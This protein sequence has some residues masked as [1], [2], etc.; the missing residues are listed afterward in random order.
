MTIRRHLDRFSWLAPVALMLLVFGGVLAHGWVNWDD[1]L[2]VLENPRLVPLSWRGLGQ[3]WIRPYRGLY[4]PVSYTAFAAETLF[5]R[6]VS[7]TAAPAAAVF[8]GVSLLVHAGCVG[9]VFR[10]LGRLE[11]TP[12]AAAA[13][14]ALFAI[15]PLQVESVAW[16]SEQRGLLAAFFSL[17][18]IEFFLRADCSSQSPF[19]SRDE[20]A[21]SLCFTT[22]LLCKPSA[23][24]AP[25]L[26]AVLATVSP[27]PRRPRRSAVVLGLWCLLAVATGWGTTALQPVDSGVAG[28]WRLRPIVAGNALAFYAGK[29]VLPRSL[30]IDYGLTP[31]AIATAPHALR[32]AIAVAVALAAVAVVPKLRG[33]RLPLAIFVVPLLPVLGFV[34]FSFEGISVVADRYAYLAMLGPAVAVAKAL[35][36]GRSRWRGAVVAGAIAVLAAGAWFQTAVWRDSVALAGRALAVNGGTRG[37]LNN[38]GLAFLERGR[39][40]EA[41]TCFEDAIACDPGYPRSR[42]NL[43]L[44]WH[45]TGRL[46]EAEQAYREALRLDTTYGLAR[47]NLGIVLGQTGRRDEAEREFLNALAID[48]DHV[49]AARNLANLRAI[50]PA[51]DRE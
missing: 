40:A 18:A 5:A 30:C 45:R 11:A 3:L 20:L 51:A 2:H 49:D 1:P 44:A 17:L 46:A 15:H 43:G 23:V 41:V 8:H 24:V 29:V 4:V 32:K 14:A 9:L 39:F 38:L 13:G 22:A 35:D 12:W 7:A 48:P 33:C 42:F 36:T 37:T 25:A 34:P 26:A 6:A 16:I 21:A 31:T 50:E 19:P 27:A 10:L 28:P 47:N